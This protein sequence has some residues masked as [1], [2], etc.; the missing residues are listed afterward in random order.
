MATGWNLINNN[1]YYFY[2]DGHMAKTEFIKG[3]F[4]TE[5]GSMDED[6]SSQGFKWVKNGKNQSHWEYT[7]GTHET[8][9]GWTKIDGKW[10]FLYFGQLIQIKYFFLRIIIIIILQII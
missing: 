3:Y 9:G 10:Y 1:W 6:P 8:I 5:N 2:A 7:N 4:L